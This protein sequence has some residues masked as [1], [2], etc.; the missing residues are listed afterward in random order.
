[1][2]RRSIS[3][4]ASALLLLS[5]A[6]AGAAPEVLPANVHGPEEVTGTF[7][8]APVVPAE[9]V[10]VHFDSLAIV[11]A[12]RFLSGAE[13]N[14]VALGDVSRDVSVDLRGVTP[15]RALDAVLRAL[16]VGGRFEGST[17]FLSPLE[18]RVLRT[19]LVVQ[20][21]SV[22]WQELDTGIA[23][24][25]SPE[26]SVA[27]NRSGGIVSVSDRPRTLDRL[28]EHMIEVLHSM[29]RQVEIEVQVVE[30][31]YEDAQGAGI[32][33]S[34]F[35]GVLDPAWNVSGGTATGAVGFQSTTDTREAFQLGILRAGRWKAFLDAFDEQISLN[36]ISRPRI[37]AL[38]NQPAS[39]QVKERIPYLTKTV[40]TEGGVTRTDFALEFDEAGIDV[41]VT[42]SVA[43]GGEITMEVHP[44]ISSVVGFTAS[45]PDLGPQPIIDS[46]ETESLVR[47]AEGSS[48]VM[49]GMMQDRKNV[50][51]LGVPVLSRIPWIGRLFRSEQVRT[52]KTEIIIVLTPRSRQEPGVE[53]VRR[54]ARVEPV[55]VSPAD[56][57]MVTQLAAARSERAWEAFLAGRT[58][59]ALVA[60]RSAA[61]VSPSGWWAAN[62][63]GLALQQSGF[64]GDAELALRTAVRATTPAEPVALVNWGTLLLHRGRAGEAIAPL[65]EAAERAP[66]GAVRD[67]AMLTWALALELSGERVRALDVLRHEAGGSTGRLAGRVAPRVERLLRDLDTASLD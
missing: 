47:L 62:N 43:E 38:S 15:G 24:L 32:D 41:R 6:A 53:T 27:V 40:S 34:L 52:D 14:V 48:L 57:S 51:S 21:E 64:L 17:L 37:T 56:D 8:A 35:D 33:W 55:A 9:L 3:I 4:C 66:E 44:T 61:T 23:G 29:T 31:V 2:A 36:M 63:V 59:Q 10:D 58:A 11:D 39:F 60:A 49:G 12:I 19:P 65:R 1:M 67:E 22:I 25:L 28:E 46:R 45:L 50:S 30:A 18:D 16:D 5:A 42:A 7:W 20:E 13:T 26:G 54:F